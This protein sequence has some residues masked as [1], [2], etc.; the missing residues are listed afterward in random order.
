MF[1]HDFLT[2]FP[3]EGRND[4]YDTSHADTHGLGLRPYLSYLGHERNGSDVVCCPNGCGNG[5]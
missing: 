4:A 3:T 2:C 5:V 1:D